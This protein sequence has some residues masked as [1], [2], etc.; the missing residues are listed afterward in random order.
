MLNGRT[1]RLVHETG[2]ERGER[3]GGV[4][5]VARSLGIGEESL[6]RWV[7]QAEVDAGVRVGLT[8]EERARLKQLERK[9]RELRRANKILKSAAAFFKAELDRRSS[10]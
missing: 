1:V 8:S 7:R 9:N 10:R 6:R 3:Q 4:T 2:A 5:G